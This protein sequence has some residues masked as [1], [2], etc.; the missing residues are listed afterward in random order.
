MKTDPEIKTQKKIALSL[1]DWHG[2]QFTGLYAVGSCMLANA[3][4][5]RKY[6]PALHRGHSEQPPYALRMAISELRD[7]KKDAKHPECVTA[8]DEQE[9]NALADQLE[10][11]FL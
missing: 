9:C 1:L 4:D 2:G 7:L 11:A 8:K 5:G 10:Q 3:N 6:V